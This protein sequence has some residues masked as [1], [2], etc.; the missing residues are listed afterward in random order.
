MSIFYDNTMLRQ[1]ASRMVSGISVKDIYKPLLVDI[2]LRRAKEYNISEAEFKKDTTTLIR[3]LSRI[4]IENP[5]IFTRGLSGYYRPPSKKIGISKKLFKVQDI[6]YD[7]IYEALTHEVYHVL[8]TGPDGKDIMTSRNSINGEFNYALR[9]EIVSSAASRVVYR[10]NDF[11]NNRIGY[12][13][14]KFS[15]DLIA[16][17]YGITEKEFLDIA[18]HGKERLKY[19]LAM[20]EH[21]KP[22]KTELFLDAM[23]LNLNRLYNI[24]YS[25][26]SK[27]QNREKE[28]GEITDCLISMFTLAETHI[29]FMAKCNGFLDLRK[30]DDYRFRL[31]RIDDIL[32]NVLNKYSDL[33]HYNFRQDVY[34]GIDEDVYNNESMYDQT[35]QFRRMPRYDSYNSKMDPDFYYSDNWDNSRVI[36]Y[37]KKYIEP[38]A[39]KRILSK[40]KQYRL[41][42][43]QQE[44]VPD[45]SLRGMGESVRSRIGWTG[46]KGQRSRFTSTKIQ[47]N[48]DRYYPETRK[49]RNDGGR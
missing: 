27:S 37:L 49:S 28:I 18:I 14:T 42:R 46:P 26:S 13:K 4:E 19:D 17:T 12:G 44:I 6:N 21:N 35:N 16:A 10:R 20:G 2:L 43:L 30:R 7:R 40:P 41:E 24:F 32:E 3:C 39:K 31:A 8:A 15:L 48:P 5:N 29:N 34:R 23:E 22:H 1:Y 45:F 38:E 9:E 25:G 36:S 11:M 33:Y 47:S